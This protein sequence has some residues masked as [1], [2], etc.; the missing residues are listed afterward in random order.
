LSYLRTVWIYGVPKVADHHH[1]YADLVS[2]FYFI[3]NPDPDFHFNMDPDS[4]FYFKAD[5]DPAYHFMRIRIQIQIHLKVMGNLRPV[6]YRTLQ[7]SILE[8]PGLRCERSHPSIAL[9]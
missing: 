7:G 3:A 9:F 6:V 8:P 5:P 1:F 2:A 4:A